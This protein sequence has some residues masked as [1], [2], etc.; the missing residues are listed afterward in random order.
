MVADFDL[1]DGPWLVELQISAPLV[2]TANLLSSL[3]FGYS[4][5]LDRNA[6]WLSVGQLGR[7]P[8][9]HRR[10]FAEAVLSP[11]FCCPTRRSCASACWRWLA[12]L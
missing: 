7:L 1:F 11:A 10:V 3:N 2:F 9:W 6:D 5:P 12:G 8:Q 4:G